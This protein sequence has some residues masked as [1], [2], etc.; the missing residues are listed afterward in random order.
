[1]SFEPVGPSA[2]SRS[3]YAASFLSVKPGDFVLILKVTE[4]KVLEKN[5]WWI[6][7]VLCCIGSARDPT[8]S[9]LFQVSNID[10]GE[11]KIINA[12]LME[13]IVKQASI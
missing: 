9:S 2:V 4:Y 7:Q 5:D 13:G 1:M 8:S 12:D 3:N 6:G 10:T 11:I